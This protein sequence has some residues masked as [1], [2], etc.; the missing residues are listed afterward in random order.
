LLALDNLRKVLRPGGTITAIEGDHGTAV[1]YPDT[2]AADHVIDCLVTLQR[3]A[4]GNALIGRELEH[5]LTDAGFVDVKVSP[6]QTYASASIT[7]SSEAVRSI[8]I[9]M[10]ER[11]P[12]TGD[13]RRPR[14]SG[15]VGCGD[16]GPVPDNGTRRNVLLYVF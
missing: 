5:L 1:F 8:F 10:I 11:G 14:G 15:G 2:P 9:A 3:Q 7:G 6:R 12:R 4:G 13:C 16:Q